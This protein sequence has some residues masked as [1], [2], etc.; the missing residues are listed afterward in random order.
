MLRGGSWNNESDNCRA[1]NRNN[2]NPE[3]RNDNNGFRLLRPTSRLFVAA[4]MCVRRV[5]LD[6]R[7]NHW[8]RGPSTLGPP[9]RKRARWRRWVRSAPDF[10]AGRAHIKPGRILEATPDAPYFY[11]A[12]RLRQPPSNRPISATNWLTWRYWPSLIHRQ[13]WINRR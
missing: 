7:Y 4:H 10:W 5:V 3:N 12:V 9:R 13:R 6:N 8:N 1:A 2:N 11:D